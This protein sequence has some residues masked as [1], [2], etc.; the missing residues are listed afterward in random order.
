MMRILAAGFQAQCCWA[1]A[2]IARMFRSVASSGGRNRNCWG[3]LCVCAARRKRLSWGLKRRRRVVLPWCF[4]QHAGLK[5]SLN[6]MLAGR[7]EQ[8]EK[9]K[10]SGGSPGEFH[11]RLAVQSPFAL[12]EFLTRRPGGRSVQC[13]GDVGCRHRG[14]GDTHYCDDIVARSCTG[15]GISLV[16]IRPPP[17]STAISEAAAIS[18]NM[19]KFFHLLL[20]TGTPKRS[21]P[22]RI[23]PPPRET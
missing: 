7:K 19:K 4:D 17:H 16:C 10:K 23:V 14:A 12:P 18:S 11:L 9:R 15:V 22:E 5:R 21:R 2:L 1:L 8:I 13:H 6:A 3:R 20:R